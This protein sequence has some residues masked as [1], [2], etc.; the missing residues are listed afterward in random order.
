MRYRQS[1]HIPRNTWFEVEVRWNRG[2]ASLKI[3][4]SNVYTGI[5][6]PEFTSG[7]SGW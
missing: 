4:G 7:E 6:Q 5:S 2:V 1:I 3:N